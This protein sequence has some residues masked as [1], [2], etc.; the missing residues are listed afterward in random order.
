MR[1]MRIPML[2]V[3]ALAA[4]AALLADDLTDK[5][6]ALIEQISPSIVTVKAVV[7][8]EMSFGGQ[9]QKDESRDELQGV[10]VRANGLIMMTNGPFRTREFRGGEAQIK[11]TPT[12][13]KVVVG[14]EEKEYDAE[15]VATD[16]KLGLAF[17][18][19][20]DLGDRQLAAVAFGDESVKPD[21]GDEVCQVSR[22]EKGYD[23]A[24][25]VHTAVVNG[26]ITKPRKALM[27]DGTVREQ[28]LPVFTMDGEVVG[29]LTSIESGM[30][31]DEDMGAIFF[32]GGGGRSF[33]VPGKVVEGL[34]TQAEKQ[35]ADAAAGATEGDA[36]DLDEGGEEEGDGGER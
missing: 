15:L 3:A 7:T 22:L 9:G 18:R 35:A 29:A 1:K 4:P 20:K 12:E 25:Y 6:Q 19:I 32:G 30:Q 24:T 26:R 2:L 8:T 23:Y 5:Y 27:L 33:V 34:I 31:E 11:R 14:D 21:I 28:G 36:K 16:S 17:L 13:L 10:V